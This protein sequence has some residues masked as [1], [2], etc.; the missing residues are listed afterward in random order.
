MAQSFGML[1]AAAARGGADGKRRRRRSKQAPLALLP[2][3]WRPAVIAAQAT[4]QES[5]DDSLAILAH[6]MKRKHVHWTF[7]RSHARAVE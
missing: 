2:L 7:A 6:T 4:Q 3:Q 1:G 5:P